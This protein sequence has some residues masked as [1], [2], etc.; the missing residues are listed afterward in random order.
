AMLLLPGTAAL[1]W[2]L[3]KYGYIWMPFPPMWAAIVLAV[4]GLEVLEINPGNRDLGSKIQR[5]SILDTST[6]RRDDEWDARQRVQ[7]DLLA[8]PERDAW[9]SAI[10][11][12]EQQSAGRESDRKRLL[13]APQRNARWRLQAVDFFNEDLVRFLSFNNAILSSI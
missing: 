1:S 13:A 4:P 7:A 10:R 11:S 6:S 2:G 8:G 12:T 3:M 5:L 9:L